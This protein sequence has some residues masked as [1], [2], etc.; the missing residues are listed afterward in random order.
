MTFSGN[1]KGP[2]LFEDLVT[3]TSRS[4]VVWY[5]RAIRSEPA[6]EAA[7]GE[8]G[9][10]GSFSVN[11]PSP[12]DADTTGDVT[13]DVGAVAVGPDELVRSDDGTVD[14]ALGGEVDD[15]VMPG[16][17]GFHGFAV[18]DVSADEGESRIA[19]QTTK[20]V[21]ISG[22]GQGVVDRHRVVGVRQDLTD[23]VG[24]DEAGAAGDEEAH[25]SFF[26]ASSRIA[27]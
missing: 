20:V 8:R 16:K 13:H 19:I 10:R 3:T 1:W 27:G 24:A 21:E 7:Y 23:V 15:R 26:S 18:A 2:K 9:P 12:V 11:D 6:L 25:A 17:G 4:W 5:E 14:V 22:V